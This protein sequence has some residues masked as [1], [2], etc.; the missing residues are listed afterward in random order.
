MIFVLLYIVIVKITLESCQVNWVAG[1]IYRVNRVTLNFFFFIFS[2]TWPDSSPGSRVDQ[3]SRAGFQNHVAGTKWQEHSAIP[4]FWF[5]YLKLLILIG[6]PQWHWRIVRTTVCN[7]VFEF[8]RN[9]C[10][11]T[12]NLSMLQDPTIPTSLLLPWPWKLIQLLY[13]V[14]ALF[15]W[16]HESWP[17]K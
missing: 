1:S 4:R 17:R 15:S 16:T 12:F 13:I 6:N 5:D 3:L 11:S 14:F 9:Y 10:S 7:I 8:A 2:S